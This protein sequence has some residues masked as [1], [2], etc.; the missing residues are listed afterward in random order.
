M[1]DA[2]QMAVF[3]KVADHLKDRFPHKSLRLVYAEK[4][5]IDD[6][7][8][9][10]QHNKLIWQPSTKAN[11]LIGMVEEH[12]VKLVIY[13]RGSPVGYAFGCYCSETQALK[14]CWMEKRNDAHEDL[15]HQ[16]LGIVLDA[17]AAYAQFL[18]RRGTLVGTIAFMS[19]L[20]GAK[21]YYLD[22]GFTYIPDFDRGSSAMILQNSKAQK[23]A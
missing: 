2:F 22:S 13:Y 14:V 8:F 5:I 16:M 10:K 21:Q 23:D 1:F 20:E 19:P 4:L 7:D 18:Q 12:P 17:Y 15:E 9:L 3:G 6:L 11:V